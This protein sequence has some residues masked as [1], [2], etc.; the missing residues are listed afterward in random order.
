MAEYRCR[1]RGRSW[2]FYRR[3]SE[4]LQQFGSVPRGDCSENIMF[5]PFFSAMESYKSWC[6]SDIRI[7]F[8][9]DY[10]CN[11]LCKQFKRLKCLQC[12]R[13]IGP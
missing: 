9:N 1:S 5:A 11:F 6:V 8:Y 10:K 7:L 12:I 2:L 3:L 4:L 13:T